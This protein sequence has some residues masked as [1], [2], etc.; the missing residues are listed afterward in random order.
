MGG[1]TRFASG[2]PT[3]S[4]PLGGPALLLVALA[5]ALG[6]ALASPDAG[7]S[8]ALLPGLFSTI[9][10][11]IVAGR[12]DWRR[13]VP[14]FA[15][16]AAV[17][18]SLG[19]TIDTQAALVR[20]GSSS[21]GEVALGLA[22]LFLVGVLWGAIGGAGSAWSAVVSQR[23][24]A[25]TAGPLLAVL[26]V[27][28]LL[29]ALAGLAQVSESVLAD[30]LGVELAALV[31]SADPAAWNW[32]ESDWLATLAAAVVCLS[33]WGIYRRRS[34]DALGLLTLALGWWVGFT[35]LAVGLGL[36]LTP[37][38]G[39]NWA[40]LV[41]LTVALVLWLAREQLG[42]VIWAGAITGM[43]LGSGLVLSAMV[44]PIGRA[45][46][47]SLAWQPF[48]ALLVGCAAGLGQ[49]VSLGYLSTRATRLV[50]PP[51]QNRVA[52]TWALAA[53][54]I[55]VTY[56]STLAVAD[57]HWIP[58]GQVPSVIGGWPFTA[59]LTLG[60]LLLA[61]TIG[62][63]LLARRRGRWLP[64]IPTDW[65]GKGQLLALLLLWWH[66]ALHG[67][68]QLP[69]NLSEVAG[70]IAIWAGACCA[71]VLFLLAPREE[72]LLAEHPV[73]DYFGLAQKTA[74]AT[75]AVGV[76]LVVV[77]TVLLRAVDH[78]PGGETSAA[79]A[80]P[81]ENPSAL[82]HGSPPTNPSSG[83]AASDD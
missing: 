66:M 28:A 76:L 58:R 5:G 16:Y 10:A 83:S 49:A 74:L 17:A 32:L 50:E 13:R 81:L 27:W 57:A 24:L 44:E 60:Y 40:G 62:S 63:V 61:L 80:V 8:A 23:R 71:T 4:P 6:A 41:G 79:T 55:G 48:R 46:F 3:A 70:E 35:L 77:G 45:S 38:A 39:G 67:S 19:G 20:T 47:E 7:E 37:G 34:S 53:V 2:G 64:A 59:V 56:V 54:L 72:Q 18:W 15:F 11:C 30:A 21:T 26:V 33:W 69:L 68:G 65:L 29:T 12:K 14:F 51:A 75:L 9:A 22:A 52:E 36:E 82:P 42:S 1:L 78:G 25:D 73:P 31:R 43:F